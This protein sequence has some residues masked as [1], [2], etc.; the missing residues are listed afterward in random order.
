[1]QYKNFI[2][3]FTAKGEVIVNARSEEDAKRLFFSDYQDDAV[4]EVQDFEIVGIEEY[5]TLSVSEVL[6]D[7]DLLIASREKE[8]SPSDSNLSKEIDVL[9]QT[10]E[11]I[12]RIGSR[13]AALDDFDEDMEDLFEP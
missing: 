7:L 10:K 12:R 3:H 9:K 8:A 2:V 1:M 13:E 6:S 11:F 4:R 5:K